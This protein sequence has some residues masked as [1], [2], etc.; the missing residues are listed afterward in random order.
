MGFHLTT[1]AKQDLIEIARH[2]EKNW[3]EKQRNFYLQQIDQAFHLLAQAP[4]SGKNCDYILPGYFKFSVG[5]H[6]IFYRQ[7]SK[8]Q[9]QI[10]RI[11]HSSMDIPNHLS[12]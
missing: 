1:K 9:I 7:T 3:G 12:S 5:K 10:V 11:L 4:K 8:N 6:L 2:S